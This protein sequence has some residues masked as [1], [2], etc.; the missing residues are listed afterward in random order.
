MQ[1]RERSQ[2]PARRP[3]VGERVGKQ[4]EERRKDQGGGT[5]VADTEGEGQAW[6]LGRGS[7]ARVKQI[8]VVNIGLVRFG[9]IEI[10]Q[11]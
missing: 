9:E 3:W 4:R 7:A 1:I 8:R 11:G 5:V 10:K 2:D 6:G